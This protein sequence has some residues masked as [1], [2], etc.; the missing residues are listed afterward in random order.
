MEWI[1]GD[2]D[3]CEIYSDFLELG[4]WIGFGDGQWSFGKGAGQIERWTTKCEI[5]ICDIWWLC[6][7]QESNKHEQDIKTLGDSLNA[8]SDQEVCRFCMRSFVQFS[9]DVSEKGI[10]AAWRSHKGTAKEVRPTLR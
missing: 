8:K 5:E 2:N 4:T 10:E 1:Q 6:N 9:A 7:C 3:L